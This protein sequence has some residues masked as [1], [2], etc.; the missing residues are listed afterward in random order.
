MVMKSI[1]EVT[2]D[3]PVEPPKRGRGR[4]RKPGRLMSRFQWEKEQKLV[5]GRPAGIAKAIRK[6]EQRL[7]TAN[8]TELVIDSIINAAID[9]GHPNQKAAWKLLTD[10][11]L[12]LSYFEKDKATGQRATVNIT[13][14][15]LDG[16]PSEIAANSAEIIEGETIEG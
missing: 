2:E 10:R 7:A 13:I 5:T 12:P 9:D 11:M 16:T 6:M 8:R 15:G 4:P 3:M 1:V 14:S